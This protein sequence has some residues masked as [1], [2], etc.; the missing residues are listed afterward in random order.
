MTAEQGVKVRDKRTEVPRVD[1]LDQSELRLGNVLGE[2]AKLTYL[3]HDATN[4]SM[5]A[6]L[7]PVSCREGLDLGIPDPKIFSN[8]CVY[9]PE[10]VVEALARL[11]EEYNEVFVELVQKNAEDCYAYQYNYQGSEPINHFVQI[12]MMGLPEE[13]LAGA[14]NASVEAVQEVLRSRVFEIENSV[15]AYHLLSSL[16]VTETQPKTLFGETF[17]ARLDELR[18]KHQ[19]PIALLAVTDE[20]YN[21]MLSFEFGKSE[22]GVLPAEEVKQKTGF[23]VFMGPKEFLAHLAENDGVCQYMLYVRASA[24]TERLK[25]PRVSVESPLLSD[26]ALRAVIR[27]NALTFNIDAPDAPFENRI[28]DTKEYLIPMDMAFR[29]TSLNDLF[30]GDFLAYMN[31]KRATWDGYQGLN[32]LSAPFRDFLESQDVAVDAVESGE[33]MLRAKPEKE[34]YGCYGHVRGAVSNREFKR[35]VRQGLDRRG[36][37]VV[38]VEMKMPT[39]ENTHDNMRMTYIDRNFFAMTEDGPKFMGGFRAMMDVDSRE[40]KHGRIHGSNETVWS[41]ILPASMLTR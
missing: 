31:S 36:S 11:Y 19:K 16:F 29:I 27:Q 17:R 21:S 6:D 38:Q 30:D 8:Y 32:R 20:K 24:P 13:F 33:V 28:N 37:Y 1:R 4:I 5:T 41:E 34:T 14:S 22:G 25:D 7:G 3:L 10:V 18:E 12:D 26:S 35:E 15:A 39:I 40:A 2:E 9:Y 23:D